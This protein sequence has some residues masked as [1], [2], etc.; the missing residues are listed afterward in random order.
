MTITVTNLVKKYGDYTAVDNLSFS[1]EKPGVFGLLGTNGA[2]KTTTIRMMLGMLKKDGGTI[3]WKGEKYDPSKIPTGYLAEERGIYSKVTVLDQ[4]IY[5]AE[6]KGISKKEAVSRIDHW[7]KRLDI[8]EHRN[9]RAEQLS[10]GNQQKIQFIAALIADPEILILDEPLSGLDPV[11]TD[12]F[13]E[14][15]KEEV[16]KNKY[17]IMSSHQMSTIEEFC[18]DLVILKKGKTV[19]EGNL[20]KI[21]KSYG[22]NRLNLKCEEDISLIIKEKNIEI[23][24]ETPDLLSLRV[25]DERQGNELLKELVEKNVTIVRFELREPTL[26]EIFIEKVGEENE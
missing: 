22:R 25:E 8:E 15:I 11:N 16:A 7:L 19:L 3:T 18:T 2:G 13:K 24:E 23:I 20:G 5:F 1:M 6:L 14:V 21:K 4:L 17:I 26:H 12:L 9:K 10:K